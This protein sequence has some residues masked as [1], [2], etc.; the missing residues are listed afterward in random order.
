MFLLTKTEAD[1][2]SGMELNW[3][4]VTDVSL[5]PKVRGQCGAEDSYSLNG[6]LPCSLPVWTAVIMTLSF[7]YSDHVR[8]F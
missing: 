7:P 6:K 8:I 4:E 5:G 1:L 3:G 2:E